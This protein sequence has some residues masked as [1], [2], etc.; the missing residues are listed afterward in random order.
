MGTALA[1]VSR[2][3]PIVTTAYAPSA[4]NNVYW[5]E[6]Y[7]N[8]SMMDEKRNAIYFDSETPRVFGNASPFDP[9]LFLPANPYAEELVSGGVSGKYSPLDVAQWIEALAA[10]G[11][12][13]LAEAERSAGGRERPEYRRAKV[14]IEIQAGLGEFF[15]AKFRAGVLFHLYQS[16]GEQMG[17]RA[18]I[19]QYQKARKAFAAATDAAE[20]VYAED[21]TF[22]EQPYLRGHWRD[23]LPAI[24]REI[25]ALESMVREG[26]VTI[27]NSQVARAFQM[28]VEGRQR[29]AIQVE[30]QAP[31]SFKRG[32]SL[33]LSVNAPDK[34]KEMRLHYRRVN[35]AE[36]YEATMM[37]KQASRFEGAIDAEYTRTHFPLAYYFE[38]RMDD[39]TAGLYPGFSASLTNQPYFVVRGND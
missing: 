15:A 34:V 27:V 19:E 29:P 2:I 13:A 10:K 38:V 21:V 26:G 18:V 9:E 23:R 17:L 25:S 32:E 8:E 35:Q 16:S 4:A 5:P 7:T 1:N 14:D 30:H 31:S 20:G 22:G 37:K 6:M 12:S 24:D 36:T 33:G 39:G 3:L 11:R 28:F